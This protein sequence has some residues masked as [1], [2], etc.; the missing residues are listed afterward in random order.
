MW[1]DTPMINANVFTNKGTR[2]EINEL[3]AMK[4]KWPLLLI[5][6]DCTIYMTEEVFEKVYEAVA[7]EKLARTIESEIKS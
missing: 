7:A 1:Y 2:I 6:G 5:V 3:T 4:D